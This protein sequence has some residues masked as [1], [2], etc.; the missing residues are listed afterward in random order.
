MLM[1]LCFV[2]IHQMCLVFKGFPFENKKFIKSLLEICF[3]TLHIKSFLFRQIFFFIN[4]RLKSH[5]LERKEVISCKNIF[6]KTI[7]TQTSKCVFVFFF[8]QPIH[9][10]Q[11]KKIRISILQEE[12]NTKSL[13]FISVNF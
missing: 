2:Y 6:C 13:I 5:I 12:K 7:S 11:E 4:F 3:S 10:S 8:S 1:L 9:K